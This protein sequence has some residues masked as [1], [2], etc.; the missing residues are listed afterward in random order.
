MNVDFQRKIDR[1]VGSFICRVLSLFR[2]RRNQRVPAAKVEKILVIL[3]SEMGSLVLAYPMFR[4]IKRRYP[5][6]SVHVLLFKKNREVLDLLKVVP[7]QQVFTLDNSSATRFAKDAI[8]VLGKLRR[9]R[10]DAVIDCELFARISSIFSFLSRAPIRV[11]FHA[12][13][14]EGLYRGDFINRPVLYNPYQHIGQQFLTLV[15]AIDSPTVPKA[16]RPVTPESLEAP[17]VAFEP[18]EI[19]AAARELHEYAPGVA[20]KALVLIYPSGGLLPIRAWPPEYYCRLSADLLREGY[21]VGV[22]G[23]H[24]DK[25]L[26]EQILAHCQSPSCVDL[27]GYTKSIRE[28]LLLFHVASLLITNDGGPGQFAAMTPIPTIIFFGPETPTLYGSLGQRA[29][30]FF[31]SLSCSPCIT[32]Y[33]HRESPCDGDNVCLKRI[34]PDRVLAKALEILQ[35]REIARP[36]ELPPPRRAERREILAVERSDRPARDTA[37]ADRTEQLRTSPPDSV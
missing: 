21:A 5:G 7:S 28:L 30:V 32:A 31:S 2:R 10:F 6:A 3:L 35:A 15:E 12:H 29:T 20:E 4:S 13:T 19:R 23:M 33:N 9:A 1:I 16:K 18:E 22:I 37:V 26:A 25:R 14:Q 34:D 8:S 11:G 17:S 24:E 27:T 36:V